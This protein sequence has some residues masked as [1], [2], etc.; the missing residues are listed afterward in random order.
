[1][2]QSNCLKVLI[3]SDLE[4]S[5]NI[6]KGIGLLLERVIHGCN[7]ALVIEYLNKGSN[8]HNFRNKFLANKGISAENLH[9]HF[10]EI[11]LSIYSFC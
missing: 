7:K 5:S 3:L 1:M 11:N 6:V 10:C 2:E 8:L 4:Y 9:K